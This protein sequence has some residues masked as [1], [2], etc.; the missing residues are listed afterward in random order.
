MVTCNKLEQNKIH[1][2]WIRPTENICICSKLVKTL[3]LLVKTVLFCSYQRD[4]TLHKLDSCLTLSQT[5]CNALS[6]PLLQ[7]N[8]DLRNR[9]LSPDACKIRHQLVSV[10]GG[11]EWSGKGT[12]WPFSI[13][14]CV[15]YF[16]RQHFHSSL[17]SP[18]SFVSFVVDISI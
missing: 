6:V 13:N 7:S 10:G 5:L 17:F 3:F 8:F 18:Q 12:R 2:I 4:C 1:K 14:W 9:K 16:M 11:G 15:A